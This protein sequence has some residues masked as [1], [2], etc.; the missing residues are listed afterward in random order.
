MYNF[1]VGANTETEIFAA[2]SPAELA[3]KVVLPTFCP[4][5]VARTVPPEV[6]PWGMV[7]LAGVTLATVLSAKPRL[8]TTPPAG[9][10]LDKVMATALATP[11]CKLSELT[12]GMPTPMVT[13]WTV[14]GMLADW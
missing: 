4:V 6:W 12:D 3:V 2:F 10:G 11:G 8:T 5:S 13:A 14:A 7:M 9:A 1:R